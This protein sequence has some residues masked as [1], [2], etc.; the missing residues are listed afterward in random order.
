MS[1]SDDPTTP[2]G[3]QGQQWRQLAELDMALRL[4]RQGRHDP[5][6]LPGQAPPGQAASAYANGLAGQA[7]LGYS[8]PAAPQPVSYH[9]PQSV[10]P[11]AGYGRTGNPA[12]NQPPTFV[13]P[14]APQGHGHGPHAPQFQPQSFNAHGGHEA[15]RASESS[16]FTTRAAHLHDTRFTPLPNVQQ[17]LAESSLHNP[18]PELRGASFDQWPAPHAPGSY[19]LGTY[20]PT[21][22][23]NQ[24]PYETQH[25][26]GGRLPHVHARWPDHDEFPGQMPDQAAAQAYYQ[27]A[28]SDQESLL[29]AGQPQDHEDPDYEVEEPRRRYR[30]VA[31]AVA[32]IGAIASG[33]GLAYAYKTLV[34]PVANAVP[35]VIKADNRPAKTHPADPGGKQFLHQDSKL[36]GRLGEETTNT[37]S[38]S[39]PELAS[40][41]AEGS[42]VRKVSTL[43][44]SRDGSIA[45]PAVE[46]APRLPPQVVAVP[47]MM[48]VDG[49]AGRGSVALATPRR[50][51]ELVPQPA[52]PTQ[53]APATPTPAA[54]RP[55]SV[56]KVN[57]ALT[58]AALGA[59]PSPAPQAKKSQR[60]TP[61][62]A[63]LQPSSPAATG[64]TPVVKTG[65]AGYVVVLSSQKSRI[66]ALKAFADLQQK[67][68]SVLDNKV[69]DVREAD[70]SARGLGTV[71]RVVI[72]PPGSREAAN[73]ICDQLKSAG[74]TGCWVTAH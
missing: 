14:S 67:Y 5:Q 71:Y 3:G 73:G 9:Y 20:M 51:I 25:H 12:D 17:P 43:V 66:D 18:H 29:M 50:P 24:R 35:P 63:P 41:D 15:V 1:W 32:L 36:L 70:L 53:A 57:P 22:V 44:V 56:S 59:P 62:G 72:G 64:T 31:I 42:G 47:G 55:Q 11:V 2:A 39:A 54:A 28:Y 68:G 30:G 45:A 61:V 4:S 7:P 48:I 16:P 10:P 58:P 38:S 74:F 23:A 19:D 69:P 27:Q 34:G 33:G 46:S 26:S 49:F 60:A 40:P 6:Q 13:A 52:E 37:T 8:G 65:T 21:G